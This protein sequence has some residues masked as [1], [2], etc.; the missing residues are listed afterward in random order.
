M[1]HENYRARSIL[2][3]YEFFFNFILVTLSSKQFIIICF[4]ENKFIE[5]KKTI[6]INQRETDACI[7][8]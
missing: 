1:L 2:T 8:F 7:N 3:P 4:R 5:E 6:I